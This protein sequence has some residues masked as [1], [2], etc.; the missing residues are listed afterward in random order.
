MVR[1][2][3]LAAVLLVIWLIVPMIPLAIWSF[4]QRWNYPDILPQRWSYET[5]TYALSDGS[6][7]LHSIGLTITIALSATILAALVGI[8][9]GYALGQYDFRGK[10]VV[11]IMLLA[12]IIVPSIATAF[13]MHTVFIGLHLTNTVFGVILAHLIPTTPYMILVMSGVFAACDNEPELQA[14][15]LGASPA[16]TFR[17]VTLPTVLPGILVGAVFTFL[18]SWSQYILTLTVGGGRVVTLPLLL[19]QFAT[20]GRNDITGAISMI[21][22]LPGILILIFT[23]RII[24]GR[25]VSLP[26]PGR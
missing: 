8:P 7:I 16:Q 13:G 6:G 23:A 17:H 19:F 2:R 4:A 1:F 15:S 10:R 22:I 24:T 12:P 25:G 5:W 3:N 18:V 26:G 14:R 11:E 20:S 9:A 21:Y